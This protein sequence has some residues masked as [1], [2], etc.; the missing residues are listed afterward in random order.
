MNV[1]FLPL[2]G[3]RADVLFTAKQSLINLFEVGLNHCHHIFDGLNGGALPGDDI[4]WKFYNLG[5]FV[6]N[7][8]IT[9]NLVLVNA[10]RY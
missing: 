3:R 7:F 10:K 6:R 2:I 1:L 5:R 8:A 9:Q 4:L